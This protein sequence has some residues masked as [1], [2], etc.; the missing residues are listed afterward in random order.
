MFS[1]YASRFLAQSQSRIGFAPDNNERPGSDRQRRLN[2]HAASRTPASRSYLHR[3]IG[4]P[5]QPGSSHVS[6]FPFSSRASI[7]HA[8]LFYSAADEFREEDDEQ[9]HEREAADFY[10]LQRSR[11]HFGTSHLEESS[12]IEDDGRGSENSTDGPSG[13]SNGIGRPG[14]IRSSWR[15]HRSVEATRAP[16]G[17]TFHEQDEDALGD[18]QSSTSSSRGKDVMVDVG[19]EDTLRS[20][21]VNVQGNEPVDFGDEE[22]PAIQQFRKKPDIGEDTFQTSSSFL[23]KET[24]RHAL[25]D[26]P[27]PPSTAE[28]SVPGSVTY[29]DSEPPQHDAFWGNLFLISLVGLFA[30]SFLMYLHTSL[31]AD[32]PALG[33]TIY[34]T[35]HASFFLLAIYTLVSILVSLLWLALLRSYVR[36]LVYTIL[37]AVPVILYSFALYPFIASFGGSRQ[38]QSIQDKAMRW[39]SLIPAIMATAWVYSVIQGRHAAGKAI[40]ILEF[41]CRILAANPALLALGFIT[42]AVVASWTWLWML[43]FTRVFLGGHLSASKNLFIINAGSWWLGVY[44]ILVYLW[45]LGVIAGIQRTVTAA[46]VSQWYFHRLTVPSPSSRQIVQAALLHS[47]STLFGTICLSTLLALVIRL[48]LIVLPRRLSSFIS[49]AAYSFVPTPIAALTNPLTLTYGAVHSLPLGVSARSLSQMTFLAPSTAATSFHPRSFSGSNNNDSASLLPYRLAKLLL[50]ATR[51]IM[52]LA[53]GFGG[54]VS[55]ARN[56]QLSNGGSTIRGSLYAYVVGLIAGAI[57]WGVLGAMEGVLAGV[58]D[59]AVVCW[60][61]EVGSAKREVRYCR[62]AGWLFG[63]GRNGA[64][65]DREDW[66][67]V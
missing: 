58:V 63:G 22:P 52:S 31:P 41:S 29:P 59:A 65:A 51:F 15:A 45:S 43:M 37:I 21:M 8:P 10:A 2:P 30:T 25:L 54:W 40:N 20:D 50:H 33:D 67:D 11:R 23:P 5:Y 1:E 61:S 56:L 36:P 42:L 32:K 16:G 18:A 7:P 44:F 6:H 26:N 14:G 48:P 47:A 38:G 39:G 12:E 49:L 4:N 66:H 17:E 62:E 35:L 46:T 60:A 55:T 57:G 34:S 13:N 64:R 19:L 24:D 53:L 28:S 27:R 3:A 9:E